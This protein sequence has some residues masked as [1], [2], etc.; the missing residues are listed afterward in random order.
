[1]NFSVDFSNVKGEINAMHGIGQPPLSGIGTQ[2]LHYLK[3]AVLPYSRL[4]DVSGLFGVNL[5]GDIM[6]IFS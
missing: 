1:M 2:Y 3:E 6:N 5:W 4:H